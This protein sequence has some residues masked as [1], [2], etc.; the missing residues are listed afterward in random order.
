MTRTP[1]FT[2]PA[3][4]AA[5]RAQSEAMLASLRAR[6]AARGGWIPLD[7]DLEQ[8]LYAPGLGYYSAGAAKIG[9]AGDFTTAPGLSG[10]FCAFIA[11]PCA[12]L[13]RGGGDLLRLRARSRAVV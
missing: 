10:L 7:E 11:R 6:I 3:L 1:E 8:L 13:L 2:M 12:P 5:Q 9:A 4:D